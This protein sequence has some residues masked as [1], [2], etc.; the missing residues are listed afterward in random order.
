MEDILK[1]MQWDSLHL[2]GVIIL[3]VISSGF[4]SK[5]YL[6]TVNILP[7]WKTLIV[8]FIFTSLYVLLLIISN[9][10]RVEKIVDYFISFAIA[11]SLYDL[12][13]K[14]VIKKFFP[15]A[16]LLIL[17]I[18]GSF[19]F[20]GCNSVKRVLKDDAKLE[21]VGRE[22]EKK[23]PCINDTLPPIIIPGKPILIKGKDSAYP[24]PVYFHLIEYKMRA[25]DTS[26]KNVKI[27]IDT[28]GN[29]SVQIKPCPVD[30]LKRIDT[31]QFSI[32]DKRRLNIA[33]DSLAHYKN[34]LAFTKLLL[35]EQFKK[36]EQEK[37]RGDKWL[38][39]FI[40]LSIVTVATHLLRS[41]FKV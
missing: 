10:F 8:S 32:T 28:L 14:P 30:T 9:N 1:F 29:I 11:T 12:I 34:Q 17:V 19:V 38:T 5:K 25:V 37:S 26:I 35:E 7:A 15:N 4:W 27:K 21:K 24:V 3:L 39:Y 13:L 23:N 40:V 41:K 36:T 2:D 22:W 16:N 33:L 6:D 31:A 20:A 18:A